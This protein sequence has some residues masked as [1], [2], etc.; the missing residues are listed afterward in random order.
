MANN[1]PQFLRTEEKRNVYSFE[2]PVC[3]V[4]GEIGIP[5]DSYRLVAHECGMLFIQQPPTG[6]FSKPM[7]VE[8]TD[9][10]DGGV[11]ARKMWS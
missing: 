10:D 7:L 8:V 1:M 9:C 11:K 2:C 5:K 3:G 4:C 6:L